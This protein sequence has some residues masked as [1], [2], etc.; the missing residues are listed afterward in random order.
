M[1]HVVFTKDRV[2]LRGHADYAPRGQDIV[3]AAASALIYALIGAL[4][5]KHAIREV[6]IRPGAVSVA[7]KTHC[8]AE[9]AMVRQG[10]A[11]L[12]GQYPACVRIEE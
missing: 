2:T 12:A 4:E 11:Q 8:E 10:L 9:F 6:S 1:I 7:S 5:A 3:C